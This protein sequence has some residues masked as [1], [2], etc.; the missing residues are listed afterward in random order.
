MTRREESVAFQGNKTIAEYAALAE[1]AEGFGFGGIG[2][3]ADLGFQPAIVPLLTIA[4]H[5][6]RVRIRAISSPRFGAIFAPRRASFGLQRPPDAGGGAVAGGR[7]NGLLKTCGL[8]VD[9]T[10]AHGPR[11][12]VRR[13]VMKLPWG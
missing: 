3:Y 2:V 10:T 1:L 7:T 8:P 6:K 4:R 9:P 11:S 12:G 13:E 5:T